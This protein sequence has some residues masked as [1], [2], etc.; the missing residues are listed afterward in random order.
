MREVSISDFRKLY[1]PPKNSHKGQNGRLMIIAGSKMYHGASI[2]PL[3][4]ASRIV[5]LVYYS[6]I[7]ENNKIVERMKSELL[8]FIVIPRKKVV[9]FVDECDSILIGPGLGE[10]CFTKKMTERLLKRYP[11]KRFVLDADSLKVLNPKFLGKNCLITPHKVEFQR[12]FGLPADE[13]RVCFMAKKFGCVILLKG[14][15]DIIC[16]PTDCAVNKTGNPGMTKGGTG[17]VLAGLV[18]ALSCKNDLFLAG[19]LGAFINGLA[20]DRLMKR[21]SYYYNASD[22]VEEI[23]KTM[24]WLHQKTCRSKTK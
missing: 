2:L 17:D 3:K 4:V 23:P 9:K 15:V 20:G 24:M 16:S 8:D 14:P 12:L 7:E 10:N 19:C 22:L 1:I 6:S 5:D 18:A 13:E 11:E 21:F